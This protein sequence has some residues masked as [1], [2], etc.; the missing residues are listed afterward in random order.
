MET[1]T[2]SQVIATFTKMASEL[3][4]ERL[5]VWLENVSEL[6]EDADASDAPVELV[7]NYGL[8]WCCFNNELRQRLGVE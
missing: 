4:T 8:A 3:S 1:A 2:K 5:R 7:T 6:A